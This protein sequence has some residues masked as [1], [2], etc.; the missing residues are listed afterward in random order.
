MPRILIIRYA[1]FQKK[2]NWLQCLNDRASKC[3]ALSGTLLYSYG[4]VK[5]MDN[6]LSHTKPRNGST[7]PNVQ[8]TQTAV[9]NYLLIISYFKRKK[10]RMYRN[11]VYI[12]FLYYYQN[13]GQLNH[14]KAKISVSDNFMNRK[15]PKDKHRKDS[16][17]RFLS[18]ASVLI[19]LQ[20]WKW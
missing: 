2:K 5:P 12:N 3:N 11:K 6:K 1:Y 17:L 18:M 4:C 10:T 15:K 16:Q 7:L 9:I 19:R 13:T 14:A 8:Y 20:Q